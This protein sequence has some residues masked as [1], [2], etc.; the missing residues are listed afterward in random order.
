MIQNVR[1]NGR[2][3]KTRDRVERDRERT[4]E[5]KIDEENNN[6]DN[7]NNRTR[8]L[9]VYRYLPGDAAAA[10]AAAAA[11]E[12]VGGDGDGGDRVAGP[13]ATGG[14]DSDP[15]DSA[16]LSDALELI[17]SV[18]W[19]QTKHVFTILIFLLLLLLFFFLFNQRARYGCLDTDDDIRITIFDDK[20][21]LGIIRDRSHG[22]MSV[23]T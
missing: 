8:C 3:R 18:S 13:A 5:K 20:L 22:N 16:P 7:N 9:C 14:G 11:E 10:A 1:K 21:I 12:D 2:I 19:K 6:N 17:P 23:V 15:L 4:K